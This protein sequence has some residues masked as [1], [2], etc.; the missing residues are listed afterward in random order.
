[1]QFP[2]FHVSADVKKANV[3]TSAVSCVMYQIVPSNWFL[4][5]LFM[6]LVILHHLLNVF[7]QLANKRGF[8]KKIV[9]RLH[10]YVRLHP[11]GYKHGS[12]TKVNERTFRLNTTPLASTP[13]IIMIGYYTS[14]RRYISQHRSLHSQFN[15]NLQYYRLC[16]LVIIVSG[17]RSRGPGFDSRRY[18][19][20]WEVVS[21]ERGPLRFVSTTEVI[22]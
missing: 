5:L 7:V 6:P 9:F 16:G 2:H 22:I 14:I 21:L 18:H 12:A 20:F 8:K 13:K 10:N 1:M 11:P 4:E 17:Y 3:W 15:E 19:I